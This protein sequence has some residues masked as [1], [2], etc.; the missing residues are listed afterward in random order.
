MHARSITV[1]GDPDA[2][3]EGIAYVRDD[4]MPAITAMEGLGEIELAIAHL[5]LPDLV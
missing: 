3:D 5:R 1:M 2:L 4:V